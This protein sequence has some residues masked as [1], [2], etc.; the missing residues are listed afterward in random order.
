MFPVLRGVG[1]TDPGCFGCLPGRR[2]SSASGIRTC[3]GAAGM[4][5]GGVRMRL[6]RVWAVVDRGGVHQAMSILWQCPR[7]RAARTA[8]R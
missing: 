8:R 6:R 3:T 4:R 5:V 1:R 2:M 7:L